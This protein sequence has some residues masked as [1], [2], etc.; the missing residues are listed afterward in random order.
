MTEID[1]TE[2]EYPTSSFAVNA[3][4]FLLLSVTFAVGVVLSACKL[5]GWLDWPAAVATA[6]LW[7]PAVGIGIAAIVRRL[8]KRP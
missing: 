1:L 3:V 2:R 5:A 6:G 8:K 4:V 7:L